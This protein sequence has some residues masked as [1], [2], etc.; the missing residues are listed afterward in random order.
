MTV[1]EKLIIACLQRKDQRTLVSVNRKWL[2]ST[3]VVKYKEALDY[4]KESGEMMGVKTFCDKYKLSAS[5]VDSTPSYYLGELKN[6]YLYATLTDK[7]PVIL[8]DFSKDPLDS[9]SELQELVSS[10]AN[11][12]TETKDT[13]YSEDSALRIEEYLERARTGGVTYLSMGAPDMDKLFYGYRRTDVITIGGRGGAGKTWLM[14]YLTHLL[15]KELQK[16]YKETGE[17]KEILFVTNEMGEDEIKERLDCIKFSLPYR[18]FLSGTLTRSQKKKYFDGLRKMKRSH[19]R[20]VYSCM[21]LEELEMYIDL[22]QPAATFVDGSYL[23]EPKL[24]EGWEKITYVTR[25]LKRITKS[26]KSPIINST[27]LK[28]GSGKGASKGFDGQDDFAY[29]S[30]YTQDSDIAFR[31]YQDADM[32]YH[33]LIGL[34]VV[35]GRR[36]TPETVLM[37]QNDLTRMV[38]S[39]TLPVEAKPEIKDDF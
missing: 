32:K 21:T 29:S 4:V 5:E 15:E 33:D 19:I 6:R 27:Q 20:I 31:M 11:T 9:F 24:G 25:G 17:F 7:V 26:R 12:A 10:L 14:V 36:V 34:E 18:D 13:L 35:K 37:F 28:R 22:Y 1:G 3:E 30:S 23:M 8:K 38:H 16:I 2:D 39:L